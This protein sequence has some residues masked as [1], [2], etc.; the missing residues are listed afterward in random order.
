MSVLSNP[1]ENNSYSQIK[2]KRKPANHKTK[3]EEVVD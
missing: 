1:H 3:T 2:L